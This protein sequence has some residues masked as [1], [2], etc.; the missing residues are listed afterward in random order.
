MSWL[1]YGRAPTT[2][3]PKWT[4]EDGGKTYVIGK[5]EVRVAADGALTYSVPYRQNT[6]PRQTFPNMEVVDGELRIP[7]AD[8]VEETLQR[9]APVDLAQALWSESPEVREQFMYCLAT[10]YSEGGIGDDD[11][12]KFLTE[13][14]GAIHS[15]AVDDLAGRFADWERTVRNSHSY[16]QSVADVNRLLESYEVKRHD[17][18]PVRIREPEADP[19]F[20][21]GGDHWNE[22]RDYWRA[23]AAKAFPAPGGDA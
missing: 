5:Y 7:V 9:L 16:Y 4:H 17:G 12:R 14:Q 11:R 13:V 22:T 10:R 23:E 6:E 8:M 19:A 20:R 1:G 15:K 21:I 18:T 3:E 2:P